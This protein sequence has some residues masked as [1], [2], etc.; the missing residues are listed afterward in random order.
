L[1]IWDRLHRTSND[2]RPIVVMTCGI[3]GKSQSSVD[4]PQSS[5]FFRANADQTVGAGKSTLAKSIISHLPHYK[6]LSIDATV[7]ETHGLYSID[8]PASSY[9][10]F[11]SQAL[12]QIRSSL[13]DRIQRGS[14]DGTDYV[15]DLAFY[16]KPYRDEFKKIIEG[17]G[18]RWVLVFLDA[19]R[20]VLWRRITKRREERDRL[21][22]EDRNG[23]SAFEV[24]EA[25]LDMYLQVF[26]KPDGEGEVRIAVR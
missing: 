23:D 5:C 16:N 4:Q 26:E 8:Y 21:P 3:A 12:D 22:V 15:L 1:Q 24:D 14:S 17:S 18:A 11:S 6:R 10:V 20:E 13:P 2:P 19:E 25:T 7:Y 9:G